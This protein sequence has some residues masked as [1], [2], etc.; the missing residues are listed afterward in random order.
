MKLIPWRCSA[1]ALLWTLLGIVLHL[2]DRNTP[3]L[4]LATWGALLIASASYL[5][6]TVALIKP[7]T[8]MTK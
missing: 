7:L 8:H 1:L 2:I 3:H 5:I 6:G 4:D